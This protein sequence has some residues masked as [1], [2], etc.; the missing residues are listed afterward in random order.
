MNILYYVPHLTQKSG[1]IRQ[2]AVG[3]LKTMAQLRTHTVYVLHNNHDPEIMNVIVSSDTLKHIPEKVGRERKWEKSIYK[4]TQGVHFLL[5]KGFHKNFRVLSFMDRICN[6]YNID[7]VHAPFQNQPFS[8]KAKNIFTLHDVQEIHFP[9]YF[10]PEARET[11]ARGWLNNIKRTDRIV[12][13]YEHVKKDIIKYFS[14]EEEKIHVILLNMNNLWFSNYSN[15]DQTDTKELHGFNNFL[16]YP[17]NTWQHKNHLRLLD[18][19]AFLQRQEG[20]KINLV[21]TGNQNE[22]YQKIKSHIDNLG[23]DSQVKFLGIVSEKE[24]F[25]LYHQSMGVVVPTTYEAGS[26]PLMESMMMRIPVVCSNVT[27]LPETIGNEEFIF[28]PLDISEITAKVKALWLDTEF[29]NR[30][31]KNSKIMSDNLIHTNTLK[32]LEKLYTVI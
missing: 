20:I 23:L 11:R 19:I 18:A 14:F 27:S 4:V 9:E 1:G 3:L 30:N 28:D 10:T 13:S 16:L 25:S 5:E 22:H 6:K 24:L 21:C 15:K 7:V 2:Y 31:I 17:A 26:F 12:V 32:R 29:R 8:R